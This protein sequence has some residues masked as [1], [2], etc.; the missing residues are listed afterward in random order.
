M[1]LV[2]ERAAALSGTLSAVLRVLQERT[3]ARVAWIPRRAGDRGA[4]EAGCLPN[5]LPGGRPLADPAAR[6]DL[7]VAWGIDS[8]PSLGPQQDLV[9]VAARQ[10]RQRPDTPG[11]GHVDPGRRVGHRTT[12]R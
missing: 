4:V 9:A 11:R 8:L 7:A 3:G 2:G 10:R 6:V 5:L 12:A 1:I